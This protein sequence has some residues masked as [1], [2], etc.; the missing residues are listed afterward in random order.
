MMK[1]AAK[2][3]VKFGEIDGHIEM[4]GELISKARQLDN[5]FFQDLKAP[6]ILMIA[7]EWK[8]RMP[9]TV[10][11]WPPISEK[12]VPKRGGLCK[13]TG[14]INLCRPVKAR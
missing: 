14:G 12:L 2:R 10:I 13:K 5:G 7:E 11:V 9:Q 3:A 1:V 4:A 6:A 8:I